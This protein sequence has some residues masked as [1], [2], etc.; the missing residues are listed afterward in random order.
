MCMCNFMAVCMKFFLD[1]KHLEVKWVRRQKGEMLTSQCSCRFLKIPPSYLQ[2][3]VLSVHGV[4]VTDDN[5]KQTQRNTKIS[6]VN[7]KGFNGKFKSVF[8]GL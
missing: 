8:V 1:K 3:S 6:I 2:Q 4:S 7:L 5:R